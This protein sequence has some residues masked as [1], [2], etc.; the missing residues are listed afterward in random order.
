MSPVGV[1][2]ADGYVLRPVD[3][4]AR[5]VMS[6]LNAIGAVG[7]RIAYSQCFKIHCADFRSAIG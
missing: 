1:H 4:I 6:V 5:A 3:H 2:F 7:E